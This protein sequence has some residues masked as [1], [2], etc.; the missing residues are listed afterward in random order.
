MMY[1][2]KFKCNDVFTANLVFH[3]YNVIY[4]IC[5]IK[6]LTLLHEKLKF[7]Q[8]RVYVPDA[9]ICRLEFYICMYYN[10]FAKCQINTLY[11]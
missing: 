4:K 3:V 8:I 9:K 2:H 11:M 6:K 5:N 10:Q 1:I 7:V